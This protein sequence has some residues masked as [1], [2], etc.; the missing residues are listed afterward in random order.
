MGIEGRLTRALNASET[1][2][3]DEHTDSYH[4]GT[5]ARCFPERA[6][7]RARRAVRFQPATTSLRGTFRTYR[8]TK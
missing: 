7:A 8:R 4:S 6:V 2:Q 5:D 1:G 3:V